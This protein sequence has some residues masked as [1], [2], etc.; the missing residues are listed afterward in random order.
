MDGTSKEVVEVITG[1][2][3]RIIAAAVVVLLGWWIA[4]VIRGLIEKLLRKRAADPILVAF[5]GNLTY[6]LLLTFVILAA[7]GQLGVQTTSFVAVVGA[8]GLA[9]G[10]ALQGA[11]ANF[12]VRPW[13]KTSDYWGVYFDT[14]ERLKKRMDAEGVTIPFPQRDVHIYE[15]KSEGK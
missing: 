2:G 13:V 11:L 12:A 10:L 3:M 7:L 15:Q 6:V 1:V 9:I 5:V 8:A 14:N 4:R